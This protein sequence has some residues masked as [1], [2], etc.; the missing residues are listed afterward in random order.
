LTEGILEFSGFFFLLFVQPGPDIRQRLRLFLGRCPGRG[1]Q[2]EDLQRSMA[3]PPRNG[4]YQRIGQEDHPHQPGADKHNRGPQQGQM[5][6][7]E[8][9]RGDAEDASVAVGKR[10]AAVEQKRSIRP[11]QKPGGRSGCHQQKQTDHAKIDLGDF[12]A[13]QVGHQDNTD[14]GQGQQGPRADECH[15]VVGTERPHTAAPVDYGLIGR[16]CVAAGG[17]ADVKTQDAE[18]QE[19]ADS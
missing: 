16:P 15:D 18:K 12:P 13:G 4:Q 3:D 10:A 9:S 14:G 1:G 19:D 17:I 8:E 7:K 5:L 11:E 6:S 2:A